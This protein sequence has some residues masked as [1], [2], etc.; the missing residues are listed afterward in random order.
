MENSK[1]KK[2]LWH[3]LKVYIIWTGNSIE[4]H[5]INTQSHAQLMC[6]QLIFIYR[7]IERNETTRM[8]Q[9][10]ISSCKA[11]NGKKEWNA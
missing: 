6:A 1:K 5:S 4:K 10:L 8:E 9:Q 7:C 11:L 2:N 3:N